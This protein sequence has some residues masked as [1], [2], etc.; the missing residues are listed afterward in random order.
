MYKT[1]CKCGNQVAVTSAM[2]G[3]D[4]VCP[5]CEQRITVPSLSKLKRQVGESIVM[6]SLADQVTNMVCN[7]VSPFDG[8]CQLCSQSQATVILP[9]RLLFL[10]ERVLTGSEIDVS[11]TDVGAGYA[12]S[13]ESWNSVFIPC[14]FCE[15]CA[16]VF[17]KKWR[18]NW[19][20]G[21]IWKMIHMI[22]IIPTAILAV[23]VIA[24]LPLVGW[25]FGAFIIYVIYRRMSR[26]RADSFLVSHIRGLGLA[27]KLLEE[28]E[29]VL[30]YD[31]FKKAK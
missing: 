1:V 12:P 4:T 15:V 24:M 5:N 30:Q 11:L 8:K 17:R 28:D 13:E 25:T 23:A 2:C 14:F 29:Y 27:A 26:K 20:R 7:G 9:T 21:I 19:M 18:E 31:T 3:G 16:E 22:W 6:E 10:H